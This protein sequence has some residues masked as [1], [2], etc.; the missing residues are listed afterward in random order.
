MISFLDDR[1][2]STLKT[3]FNKILTLKILSLD[4]NVDKFYNNEL[5]FD[6]AIRTYLHIVNAS[7]FNR[8]KLDKANEKMV[9]YIIDHC[10]YLG[11]L[12]VGCEEYCKTYEEEEYDYDNIYEDFEKLYESV[13]N[14]LSANIYE[15]AKI[16]ETSVYSLIYDYH[17]DD[18]FDDS[19]RELYFDIRKDILEFTGG[20]CEAAYW[21]PEYMRNASVEEKLPSEDEL[22]ELFQCECVIMA[23][24]FNI[25]YDIDNR[26]V[27]T[28]FNRAIGS[29]GS[30]VGILSEMYVRKN[31]LF[32]TLT[33]ELPL[34]VDLS[35]F[36]VVAILSYRLRKEYVSHGKVNN[37]VS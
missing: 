26:Y 9:M 22:F 2:V 5:S 20:C 8:E 10:E 29:R 25:S 36:I 11:D 15:F 32:I 3:N 37:R 30:G 17:D 34:D 6:S 33:S 24:T 31:R 18:I 12:V 1:E 16:D 13:I 14:I 27:A 23:I 19:K 35:T 7:Y 28:S 21:Y 4:K